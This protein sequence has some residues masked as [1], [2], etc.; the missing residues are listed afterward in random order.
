[1]DPELARIKATLQ[2][3]LTSIYSPVADCWPAHGC[4]YEYY[5]DPDRDAHV[6]EVWPLRVER[7]DAPPVGNYR[8]TT[9]GALYE[10]AEFEFSRL[11]QRVPLEHFHYSQQGSLFSIRWQQHRQNLELRVH[12]EPLDPLGADL[13][14]E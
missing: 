13:L 12:V 10:P 7:A 8:R 14:G 6:L 1:M 9:S 3:A 5:Y 4:H 11:I 2:E